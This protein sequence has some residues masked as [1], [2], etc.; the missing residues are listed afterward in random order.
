MLFDYIDYLLLISIFALGV[1][2]S[3]QDI[4]EKSFPMWIILLKVFFAIL[5]C[6]KQSFIPASLLPISLGT[7]LIFF[8]GKFLKKNLL[9]NGDIILFFISSIFVIVGYIDLFV[10]LCGVFGITTHFVF[11][12]LKKDY[13]KVPFAP[14]I[15]LSQWT[16][17][18]LS[19]FGC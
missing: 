8:T 2:I 4:K 3:V 17:F 9:G 12:L 10:I 13:E 19:L 16:V 18:I 7:L 11:W 5:W 15:I 14:S 1:I 6:V